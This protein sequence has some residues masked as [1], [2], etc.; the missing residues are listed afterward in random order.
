MK[1]VFNVYATFCIFLENSESETE[2]NICKKIFDEVEAIDDLLSQYKVVRKDYDSSVEKCL[3]SCQN[4]F[5]HEQLVITN[6][7]SIIKNVL[8]GNIKEQSD[9]PEYKIEEIETIYQGIKFPIKDKNTFLR[10]NSMLEEN[11]ENYKEEK[12][13]AL[14]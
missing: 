11:A 8:D 2:E 5:C 3:Q 9:V 13:P 6:H 7:N 1:Q 14:V 10:W 4:Q 12:L